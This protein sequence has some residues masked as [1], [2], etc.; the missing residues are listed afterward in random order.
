MRLFALDAK[1]Q[2]YAIASLYRSVYVSSAHR[3]TIY[4]MRIFFVASIS[5]TEA[6]DEFPLNISII[7]HNL[8]RT[9]EQHTE[10]PVDCCLSFVCVCVCVCMCVCVVRRLFCFQCWLW[11]LRNSSQLAYHGNCAMF[12]RYKMEGK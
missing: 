3:T 1:I 8:R 7:V 9:V 2:R 5:L 12:T 4:S 10:I 6:V 11:P